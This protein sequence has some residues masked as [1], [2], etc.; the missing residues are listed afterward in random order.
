MQ[1][2]ICVCVSL[3]LYTAPFIFTLFK[4]CPRR[5]PSGAEVSIPPRCVGGSLFSEMSPGF[6]VCSRLDGHSWQWCAVIPGCVCGWHSC[7]TAMWSSFSRLCSFAYRVGE[8]VLIVTGLWRGGPVLNLVVNDYPRAL[9]LVKIFSLF[10]YFSS[11][12]SRVFLVHTALL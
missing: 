12:L 8:N 6:L 10:L 5:C 2:F 9:L 3:Y 4:K 7:H 1:H 11:W